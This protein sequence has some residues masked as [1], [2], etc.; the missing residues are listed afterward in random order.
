[1]Q[2]VPKIVRDRLQAA[3]PAA[4]HPDADLLT[5]FAEQSLPSAER[6]LVFDH[7]ARCGDCR[8]VVAL[9]LP[10][11]ET[12]QTV[13]TPAR[14][15]WLTWPVLRWG[16]AAAGVVVVA[17]LGLLQYQRRSASS[18]VADYS[19][20]SAQVA[21]N[22]TR[23]QLTAAP[24]AVPA[25]K[26]DTDT[27]TSSRI[28]SH[29]VDEV[30]RTNGVAGEGKT[31]A[32]AA[33]SSSTRVQPFRGNASSA[34]G[35]PVGGPKPPSQFQNNYNVQQPVSNGLP[36]SGL[37]LPE[38]RS[39]SAKQSPATSENFSVAGGARTSDTEGAHSEAQLRDQ[40]SDSQ[41]FADKSGVSKTKLPVTQPA[42]GQIA[43]YVVDASGAVVP[44]ARITVTPSTTGKSATT[45]TDSQG[46]FMIAGLQ[47]GNYKAQAQAP[48]FN[49]T[50]LDLN[51]D[52]SRPSTYSFTL[53]PG[54][55]S[56]T[57]EVSA[58]S[59]LL[60]TESS[61]M[62]G[63]VPNIKGRN[64]GMLTPNSGGPLPRWTVGAGGALQRSFDQGKTWQ[65]V[66]V[67]ASPTSS[68]S[69]EII[70]RESRAKEVPKEKDA[71]KKLRKQEVATPIFRA[72]TAAGA[73]VWA[74]G[75]AGALY[76]SLD[77]GNHWTHV[78]PSSAGTVLTG[79]IVSLDFPDSQNGRVTTSTP[80]VWTTSDAG[81]TWQKQ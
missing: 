42:A 80:E 31:A 7:L 59:A 9:A 51:Y 56:E 25:A 40:S 35:R 8:E 58:Q 5:A 17:S 62:G 63:P 50:V 18:T 68:A 39:P 11:S 57:V 24:P 79:D 54:S 78:V 48:G 12:L 36:A 14:T 47:T 28:D 34:F 2:N 60:Q 37:N 32:P 75:S 46:S 74:G 70:A 15:A 66:N 73:E 64:Y 53:N 72:V 45:V 67:N 76:H 16:F 27:A 6:A 52:A 19:V 61:T 71:D 81:Q 33:P 3:K 30:S 23:P 29:G 43:G 41:L 21:R 20:P 77:A 26:Q 1:M 44:N 49:T 65:T 13:A 69:L 10:P 22:E 55:V 4:S 38:V